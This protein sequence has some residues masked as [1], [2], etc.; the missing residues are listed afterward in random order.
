MNLG[1]SDGKKGIVGM[2]SRHTPS[3]EEQGSLQMEV[4][5]ARSDKSMSLSEQKRE[6]LRKMPAPRLLP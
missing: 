6:D 5:R 1:F 2:G 4:I 3:L